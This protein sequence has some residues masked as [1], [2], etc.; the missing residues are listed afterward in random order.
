MAEQFANNANS[1]LA[2]PCVIGDTAII[3]QDAASFPNIG[4]FRLLIDNE[5]LLCTGV[6]GTVFD[7]TRGIEGT[8]EAGHTVGSAVI[9]PLTAGSLATISGGGGGPTGP[10]GG[11][12]SGTYPNPDIA[13]SIAGDALTESANVLNVAVDGSS[14]EVSGDALRIKALGVTNAMLSGAI[15]DSKLLTSYIKSDGSRAF[16]GDQSL[17]GNK[18][19]SVAD[20]VGAQDAATKA[21][22]TAQIAAGGFVKADG[23]VPFTGDQSLGGHKITNLADP[24]N[25]QDAATLAIVSQNS[26]G[27]MDTSCKVRTSSALPS[28][29]YANGSSG[30][31]AT[32]TATANGALTVD[33]RTLG[34]RDRILVKDQASALQNGLYYCTQVGDG[35]HPW[36]ITRSYDM[37]FTNEFSDRVIVVLYG[38]TGAGEV[39]YCTT[40][41]PIIGTD[42]ISFS[43]FFFNRKDTF[44]TTCSA[45]FD[46]S[47]S[48][49]HTCTAALSFTQA[50]TP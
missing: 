19:T 34:L 25:A 9:S 28:C 3:V 8:S 36:I 24:V 26:S 50:V 38:T 33:G 47:G 22:V 6:T 45:S 37:Q 40:D 43:S 21:S 14:I 17:G 1:V 31:G 12:L 16:G 35:T 15:A 39:W 46:T 11:V 30:V 7:V 44:S 27:L 42:P 49:E 18:L 2:V 32:L 10:A 20:P 4:N 48:D 13:S 41:T 23:T 5:L 29:T